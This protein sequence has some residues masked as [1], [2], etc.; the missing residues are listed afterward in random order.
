MGLSHFPSELFRPI[1]A[2]IFPDEWNNGLEVLSLRTICRKHS[3]ERLFKVS[4]K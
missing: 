2:N 1:L 4:A 3:K